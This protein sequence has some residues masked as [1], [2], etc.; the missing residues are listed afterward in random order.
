MENRSRIYA[1][2]T[3]EWRTDLE[4]THRRHSNGEP[5]SICAPSTFEWGRSRIYAPSTFGEPISN[6]R[7]V[8]VEWR[9]DLEYT[10]RRRSNGADLEYAHR[11]RWNGEPNSNIRTRRRWN[12][13]DLEYAHRHVCIVW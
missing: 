5:I 13:A 7:T 8:D 10:H 11:R 9:T 2:S 4:Y 3:F 1:P 6:I 12:G